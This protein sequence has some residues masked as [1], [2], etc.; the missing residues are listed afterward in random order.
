MRHKEWRQRQREWRDR[1]QVRRTPKHNLGK[2][3]RE[4]RA[5]RPTNLKTIATHSTENCG[6]LPG[7]EAI[8]QTS[9]LLFRNSEPWIQ[10]KIAGRF[11]K[12]PSF[13]QKTATL[14]QTHSAMFSHLRVDLVSVTV[15]VRLS[16]HTTATKNLESRTQSGLHKSSPTANQVGDTNVWR[17]SICNEPA[18]AYACCFLQ[19][20]NQFIKE[21]RR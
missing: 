13:F 20:Y 18:T 10:Q 15:G 16:V 11:Q 21:E 3:N 8:L 1:V 12:F 14:C 4:V 2:G 7:L 19:G 17:Q 6:S 9:V 5:P